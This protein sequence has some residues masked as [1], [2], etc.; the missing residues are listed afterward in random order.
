[1]AERVAA[2]GARA[3]E[4]VGV[5]ARLRPDLDSSA[6]RDDSI[7]V[8]KRFDQQRTVQVRNLEFSLDWVWDADAPQEEV[9]E[10]LGRERVARVMH[11]YNLCIIAY[12]QTG[13]GKTYTMFG[14]DEVI[15]DWS[16]SDVTLHGLAP[17]AIADIFASL[18]SAPKAS[19]FVVMASYVEVY[20]DQCNDL[21]GGRKG[22]VLRETAQRRVVVEGLVR[23]VV[24]SETEVMD[25]LRRG[26]ELRVVA[27]MKMNARSSRSH[28]LFVLELHDVSSVQDSGGAES[29]KLSLVDLAGM[30]S[31][32]KSYYVE[33]VRGPSSA[34][35]RREEARNINTSLFALGTVIERLAVAS[36]ALHGQGAAHVPY[37]DSKLTRLLQESLGGNTASAIVVTLRTESANLDETIGTLR[38][39]VRAKAVS[40]VVRPHSLLGR[41]DASHLES[42]LAFAREEMSA[43]QLLID[44]LRKEVH[45]R[46]GMGEDPSYIQRVVSA[47]GGKPM[48]QR[49]A[50]LEAENTTLRNR[51]RTLRVTT[52]WQRLMLAT[53]AEQLRAASEEQEE[54]AR[55]IQMSFGSGGGGGGGGGDDG[56]LSSTD[57]NA[58]LLA[59]ITKRNQVLRGGGGGGGGGGGSG[60]SGGG[61]GGEGRGR[62]SEEA[63]RYVRF[64]ELAMARKLAL[65]SRGYEIENVFIDELYD[66][67]NKEGVDVEQWHEFL[68]A[69]LPSPTQFDETHDVTTAENDDVSTGDVGGGGAA[70][71]A[72]GRARREVHAAMSATAPA[73]FSANRVSFC[74]GGKGD[75]ASDGARPAVVRAGSRAVLRRISMPFQELAP[76]VTAPAL[77]APH[78]T[79]HAPVPPMHA[80]VPRRSNVTRKDVVATI[81]RG[82]DEADARRNAYPVGYPVALDAAAATA[83]E[84]ASRPSA[85]LRSLSRA[86]PS[87]GGGIHMLDTAR[88]PAN[89]GGVIPG[90]LAAFSSGGG[91]GGGGGGSGGCGG[92]GGAPASIAAASTRRS[93]RAPYRLAEPGGLDLGV[94]LEDWRADLQLGI[95]S[96]E[97][98]M[99]S[100]GDAAA[101][102]ST[103]RRGSDAQSAYGLT[104]AANQIAAAAAVRAHPAQRA[105]HEAAKASLRAAAASEDA[106][107]AAS[108]ADA[109]RAQ[110]QAARHW[111]Q[112]DIALPTSAER[113]M[114]RAKLKLLP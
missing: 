83:T 22:L 27:A 52:V 25:C 64:H 42:E 87:T 49:I 51:N 15:R 111:R 38:F 43:A 81:A 101:V 76:I 113:A 97:E 26:N 56:G 18:R 71:A 94:E 2:L 58:G 1:M 70:A 109:A 68:R 66:E 75:A 73:S 53:R 95:V 104:L 62:F 7:I 32:K 10:I 17:R 89:R 106:R 39:A 114:Q 23:E 69:E 86:A 90:R 61:D 5:Y 107:G 63:K 80:P 45:A 40:V 79:M 41:L 91:G 46:D 33:S 34:P 13:S 19:Q 99:R 100:F 31:S 21:L 4:A 8:K 14:P 9:Y 67:A 11:G 29:G 110:V 12:G 96:N 84:L 48:A 93:E 57:D 36:R 105:S 47:L 88:G 98:L 54:L 77:G 112:G 35:Q 78:T 82:R 85:P 65:A 55:T 3:S 16:G 24:T 28:A 103:L 60:G 6:P 74:K 72:E 30:E 37:R 92:G 20:N 50:E 44:R 59:R 102:V 108:M